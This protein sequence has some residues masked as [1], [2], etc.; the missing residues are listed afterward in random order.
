MPEAE[1]PEPPLPIWQRPERAA[2]GPVPEHSRASIAAAGVV[3]ADAEGLAAVTMRRVATAIGAAPAS[4]YRYVEN[5]DEL[6]ALMAD[7]ATAELILSDLPSG[8][9]WRRDVL[10]VA[11]QL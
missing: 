6:L 1:P 8:A 5:R 7:A 9:G 10:A 11:R 3:L 4:L 2:R